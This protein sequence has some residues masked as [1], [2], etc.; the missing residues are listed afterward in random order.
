MK[1][2]YRYLWTV[3]NTVHDLRH[4][5]KFENLVKN[6]NFLIAKI[7]ILI[8]KQKYLFFYSWKSIFLASLRIQLPQHFFFFFFAKTYTKLKKIVIPRQIPHHL[9]T[10]ATNFIEM[11]TTILMKCGFRFYGYKIVWRWFTQFWIL[12]GPN[13]SFW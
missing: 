12:I 5:T 1:W 7:F 2:E 8:F 10:V 3:D 6:I 9:L 4:E 11:E 13:L